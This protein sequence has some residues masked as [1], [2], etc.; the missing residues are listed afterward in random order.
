MIFMFERLLVYQKSI[1]MAV[2]AMQKTDA[3]PRSHYF[4]VDQINRSAVS[5][6]ANLAEGN[7]RTTRKDRK[8]FFIIAKSS[9][10]E[11]VALIEIAS[12][13]GYLSAEDRGTLRNNIAEITRMISGLIRG[14][15]KRK[16]E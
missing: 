10:Q 13:R 11:C 3:T 7:G 9:A 15:A 4:L 6:A 14:L 5:V 16:A 2:L 1:D 12:R 8:H